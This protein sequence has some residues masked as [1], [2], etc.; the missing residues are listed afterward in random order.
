MDC[1]YCFKILK[2]S[3]SPLKFSLGPQQARELPNEVP[4]LAPDRPSQAT[5]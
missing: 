2:L 5:V 3:I 1:K 4:R